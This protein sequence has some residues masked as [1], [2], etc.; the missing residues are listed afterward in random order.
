MCRFVSDRLIWCAL[1]H[2]IC[3]VMRA[4]KW[5]LLDI[6]GRDLVVSDTRTRAPWYNL[7]P[8]CVTVAWIPLYNVLFPVILKRLTMSIA[9]RSPA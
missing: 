5:T 8:P 6:C 4:P 2:G 7:L 1:V 9:S 3:A